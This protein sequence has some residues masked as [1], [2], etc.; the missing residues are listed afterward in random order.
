MDILLKNGLI[1]TDGG[2]LRADLS[3]S[4]GRIARIAESLEPSAGSAVYDLSNQVLFPGFT[5][6]HVHLREPGFSYK[7]TI[8]SGT[9]AAAR[10]GYTTLCAM[11][12]LN[13]VPDCKGNLEA[14]L[15]IIRDTARV[16]VYPYGALTRGEK[17]K[18]LAD[19]AGM[20][21][22]VAF[23]DDG[24][25][26]QTD[27]MMRAAMQKVKEL[28][29]ILVAHCEDENLLFGGYIHD[30]AYAKLHGHAGIPSESEWRQ[31][32]RDIALAKETGCRYH[33]CHV[34]AKESVV[35]I[36]KAKAQGVDITCETAPHYL[37]LHDM[38]LQEDGRFKMNPPIRGEE[39]RQ[40]LIEGIKDGTIDM[41]ATDHAPHAAQEKN[42]GLKGS[43]NGVVGLEVAFPV[44]YTGL[45]KKDILSLNELIALLHGNPKRRFGIG[46]TV[47]EG[48]AAD[49]TV[50]DLNAEYEIAPNE[51]LSKGRSTPFEG[52]SVFGR[53]LL[54]LCGGEVVYQDKRLAVEQ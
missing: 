17:G 2:V 48:Q 11:P 15:R 1:C 43:L 18:E 52:N 54:T 23:S 8:A 5:D 32:E 37:L 34:S 40:A 13:P 26:V 50:F 35:L 6:V 12:N 28:G 41:I 24:K 3:V 29:K 49:L 30:G 33:V 7:E 38:D 36:R 9:A 47:A 22:A 21:E 44:L 39:D 46:S 14:E 45:V 31:I 51:F 53:C 25:G 42:R 10:G 16:R 20:G 19:L 27:N 4:E